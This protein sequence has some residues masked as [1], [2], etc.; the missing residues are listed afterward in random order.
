[1]DSGNSALGCLEEEKN[2]QERQAA[3]GKFFQ[4]TL[5]TIRKIPAEVINPHENSG[6]DSILDLL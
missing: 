6:A 5:S 4:Q 2:E 3:I 1:V